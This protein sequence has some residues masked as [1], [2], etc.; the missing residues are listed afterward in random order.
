MADEFKVSMRIRVRFRDVDM[1]GHVNN[2]V[3]LTYLEEARML[4]YREVMA[5]TA[6][7]LGSFILANVQIN[8]KSPAF[9]NEELDVAV[10]V[11]SMRNS[12]LIYAFRI[13]GAGG[14]RVVADGTTTLVSY[15]YGEGKSVEIPEDL[16]DTVCAFEGLPRCR[17]A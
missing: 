16:R 3:Y 6:M 7:R 2:A 11:V 13:A 4:Y 17:E 8:Y 12:S 9:L 1:L 14:G 10:R 15:D 5:R